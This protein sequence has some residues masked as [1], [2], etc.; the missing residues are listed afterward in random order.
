MELIQSRLG[1]EPDAPA[2]APAAP[3]PVAV[4]ASAPHVPAVE[5]PVVIASIPEAEAAVMSAEAFTQGLGD[6][7]PE[8]EPAPAQE[9]PAA[10]EPSEASAEPTEPADDAAAAE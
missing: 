6:D 9:D 10:E 2:P 4:S 8:G 7:E 3:E 1:V 5:E